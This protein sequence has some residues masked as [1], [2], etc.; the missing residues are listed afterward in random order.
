MK[1]R[2]R[3]QIKLTTADYILEIIGTLGIACLVFLP[4]YFY[5]NLPNEIPNHFNAYGQVDSYGK[6]SAIWL[7]PTIGLVFYFG[8]TLLNKYPHIF[9]Y[10]AK[11]TEDN[12]ERLYALGTRTIRLLKVVIALL[13]AF[14]NFKT[15]EIALNKADDMGKLYLPILLSVLIVITGSMF[16]KMRKSN[17]N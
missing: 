6:R 15:I 9:N 16:F 11:V 10:P 17:S 1:K 2:P 13:F 8:M 4:F 3:I 5:N 12:A 7:L 14:L